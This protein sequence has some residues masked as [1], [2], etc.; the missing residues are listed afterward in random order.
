MWPNK[1]GITKKLKT[2]LD[3]DEQKTESDAIS[4]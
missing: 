1:S 2:E 3:Y 4:H